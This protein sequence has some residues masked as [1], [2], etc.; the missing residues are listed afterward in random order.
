M[1]ICGNDFIPIIITIVCCGLLFVYCNS[2]LAELKNAVEKQNRVLTSFIASIQHDIRSSG[3]VGGGGA[4]KLA[5]DEAI[6]A[7]KR[8][9]QEKIVVSDDENDSD[10][11]DSESDSE[12]DDSL[13]V[14]DTESVHGHEQ[15]NLNMEELLFEQIPRDMEHTNVTELGDDVLNIVE[16][17]NIDDTNVHE[18][19]SSSSSDESQSSIPV[20]YD[21]MKI[22]EL[23]KIVTDRNLATKEE[24]KKLKKP[25]LLSLLKK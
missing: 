15:L 7:V 5:S 2:R 3:V 16:V 18:S 13:S 10:D 1:S 17:I 8:F 19:D 11:D 12:S 20:N 14:S 9:E 23:R 4:Q 25:E 21:S 6:A 22:E 24:S